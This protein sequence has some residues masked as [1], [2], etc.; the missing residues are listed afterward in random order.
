M[1]KRRLALIF[2]LLMTTHLPTW[3]QGRALVKSVGGKGFSGT[4]SR[5]KGADVSAH[6]MPN[7]PGAQWGKT[8]L[9]NEK[10]K[11]QLQQETHRQILQYHQ[12]NTLLGDRPIMHPA[13]LRARISNTY[14]GDWDLQR[15]QLEI[16]DRYYQQ[17]IAWLK[18]QPQEGQ[19]QLGTHW[20]ENS[21][22][23]LAVKLQNENLIFVGEYHEVSGIRTSV[24]DWL[25]ELHALEPNRTLVVFA[26][27][28]YLD[29]LPSEDAY[30][31]V[32]SRRGSEGVQPPVDLSQTDTNPAYIHMQNQSSFRELITRLVQTP[33]IEVYPLED[34]T[35]AQK[36][37]EQLKLLTLSGLQERNAGF[38]RVMRAQMERIRQK[39]PQALFVFYGG[40]AHTSWALSTSLPKM[41]ADEF[42]VVV[43]MSSPANALG[44]LSALGAVRWTWQ[45]S[46]FD[47][48]ITTE[49]LFYW[50]G[51]P[52]TARTWGRQVGFDY[53]LIVP[54]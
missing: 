3:G 42:P 51:D 1:L 47:P 34:A 24:A 54:D 44:S 36:Q 17:R 8:Y 46:F 45:T 26:E 52:E 27:S 14:P 19:E 6:F 20:G 5:V 38:A 49:R 13:S 35:V 16:A 50:R 32:Y 15:K 11:Q 31:Y 29:P 2:I 21:S 39:D 33:G 10:F 43:E 23:I 28:L 30:P 22:H 18:Q 48:R 4:V 53:R 12:D 37:D 9:L 25:L 7:T 41:F 40:N